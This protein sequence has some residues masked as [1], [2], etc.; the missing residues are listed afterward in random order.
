[1]IIIVFLLPLRRVRG[2]IIAKI[3]KLDF[4]GSILTL[5]W[6]APFLIALSWAGSQYPWD[7]AAVLVPLL[8]GLALLGLFIFVEAKMVSLPLVPMHIFKNVSVSACF[9]TTFMNG[10]SFYATLYVSD[11]LS[12]FFFFFLLLARR[13]QNKVTNV[14]H[15][16]SSA[17]LPD[18]P[19]GVC[20][21]VGC[22]DP[23]AH[24]G[25]N[26]YLIHHWYNPIQNG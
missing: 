26:S 4:Y 19:R 13:I 8:V 25:S 6:A 2:S 20:N 1:M 7:S 14:K 12:F 23:T 15:L 24:A 9:F 16:V 3:K 10:L 22:F 11:L 18:C 5:A 17:V 21:Q